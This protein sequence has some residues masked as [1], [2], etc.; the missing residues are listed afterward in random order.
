M[1]GYTP[2]EPISSS[3]ED[4]LGVSNEERRKRDAIKAVQKR[5][6]RKSEETASGTKHRS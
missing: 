1:G 3:F 6:K 4:E 5:Q 2:P